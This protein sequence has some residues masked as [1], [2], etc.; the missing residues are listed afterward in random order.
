[1]TTAELLREARALYA[2][3]PS[4]AP[5]DEDPD[6]GTYCPVTAVTAV[7]IYNP[8]CSSTSAEL[9]FAEAAG[10]SFGLIP[11]WNA[12]HT[13]AE[14]LAAFDKAIAAEGAKA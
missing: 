5:V 13:T 7:W 4:H 2:A 11:A 14:A 9:R 3:N 12:E 10:C 8:D 6:A 1:M